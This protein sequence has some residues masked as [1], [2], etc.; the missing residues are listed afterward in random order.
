M[1]IGFDVSQTGADKA[2]CGFLA[3]NLIRHLPG[4]MAEDEFV[5]YP[6][7]GDVYW[8]ERWAEETAAPVGANVRRGF[9]HEDFEAARS[10]WRVPPTGLDALLGA[11]DIVHSNNFFCP[12]GLGRARLVYTLYDLNF[13]ENPDWTTEA[14]RIGCFNGVFGASVQADFVVAI[15]DFTR[16]HFLATFPHY[17][18]KRTAVVHLASRFAETARE[19]P[20]PP[21]GRLAR[22]APAGFWLAIG[23]IEPRKNYDGLIEA[24]AQLKAHDR[25]TRPLVI[26]GKAGWLMQHFAARLAALGIAEDVRL[27]G[28]ASEAE[29]GWLYRNCFA[30]VYPTFWEGF[31][32]PVVEALSQGAPVISSNV[33]SI[34]EILGDAGLLIDP[35]DKESLVRAMRR[36]AGSPVLRAELVERARAQSARFSW[37][38]TARR[39]RDIYRAALALPRYADGAR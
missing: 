12:A 31:G 6:T 16:R 28:Y 15:S 21:P 7:F 36:L 18:V 34:P 2:G 5:L 20:G 3:D 37:E 39:V 17:P 22:L 29:L 23:T 35:H 24:Y 9:H 26:A 33:S 27:L 11:P 19:P 38:S 30:V 10:F 32:L 8:N 25:G 4:I 14:N 1:R 13:L